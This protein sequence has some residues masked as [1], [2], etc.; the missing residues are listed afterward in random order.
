MSDLKIVNRDPADLIAAEYNPRE[1]STE[2]FNTISDSLKRFGFVD[3][4]LINIHPDRKDIIIGGHQRTKVAISLGIEA[5]PTVEL[6]L[7][8]EMEKELNIRLNRNTGSWDYKALDEYFEKEDLIEWGFEPEDLDFFE[9]E[10][11]EVEEDDFDEEPPEDPKTELGRIYQL[12]NHRLMC[13]DSTSHDD[14]KRLMANDDK[15]AMCFT[16]PPYNVGEN[17]KLSP[18]VDGQKYGEYDDNRD[19]YCEFLKKITN[20]VMDFSEYYFCNIQML[21]NNK[22]DLLNWAAYYSENLADIMIWNKGFGQPAMAEKVCNSAF[23]FVYVFSDKGNRAIGTKKFRGT[24][25]NIF[26]IGSQSDNKFASI[27]NAT[28]PF[29]LP[30]FFIEN[31]TNKGEL[32]LD[33]FGGT[34]TT[35]IAADKLGRHCRMMELDPKYCDVIVKRYCKLKDIDPKTVFETGVAK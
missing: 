4:I 20:C 1:L 13:G 35:L 31:F 29:Q 7:T 5:V 26:E 19:D 8:L 24:I 21:A 18:N 14:L 25:P 15:A 3:P 2:Q 10:E 28:F 23:E 16:S 22:I 11:E 6:N 9:P 30:L 33:I 27:H 34:G 32:I 17:S 12:G